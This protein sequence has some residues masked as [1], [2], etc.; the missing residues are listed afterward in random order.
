MPFYNYAYDSVKL[1]RSLC[2]D[3]RDL[4]IN[5]QDVII[6]M[7]RKQTITIGRQRIDDL[8]IKALKRG[9]WYKLFKFSITIDGDDKERIEMFYKMLDELPNLEIT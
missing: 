6:N 8:T 4:Y 3:S 9:N 5:N 1:I 2:H 7:F